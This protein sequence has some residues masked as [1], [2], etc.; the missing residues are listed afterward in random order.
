MLLIIITIV[1]LKRKA[2]L[3]AGAAGKDVKGK[4]LNHFL[5]SHKSIFRNVYADPVIV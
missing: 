4:G 5:T 2:S 3:R 1:F